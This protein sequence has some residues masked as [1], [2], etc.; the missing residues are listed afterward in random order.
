MASTKAD[1]NRVSWRY[2]DGQGTTYAV[3]AKACYV[4]DVTDGP[5]Y[6]GSLSLA[7]HRRIPKD[8]KMRKV[9]CISSGKPDRYVVAY[10]DAA[11][12]WTT[13]GTEITLDVNGTDTLYTTTSRTRAEAWRDTTRQTS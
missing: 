13:P 5:K 7:T 4:Q 11:T 12:I 6:G 8:L 9:K 1:N 2:T 3:S 10:T